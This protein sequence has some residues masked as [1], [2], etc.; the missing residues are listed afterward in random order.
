MNYLDNYNL[1]LEKLSD[2]KDLIKE[3]KKLSEE[4]K[5]EA[6][7]KELSFGTGGMRGIM[8]LGTNRLNKFTLAKTALGYANYLLATQKSLR[9]KQLKLF[10]LKKL[11]FIYLK[12][13]ARLQFYHM[14]LDI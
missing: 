14:Q 3:L 12:N 10:L 13:F 1:W 8:G 4:E 6:F 11:K 5:K 7:G 2:D 9:L